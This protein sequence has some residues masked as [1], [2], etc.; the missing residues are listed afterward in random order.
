LARFGHGWPGWRC[1]LLGAKR[2]SRS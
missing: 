2:K 1:P